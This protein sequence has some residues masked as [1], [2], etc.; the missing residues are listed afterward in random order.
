MAVFGEGW[1]TQHGFCVLEEG[2]AH[3]WDAHGSKT[4]MGTLQGKEVWNEARAE[5]VGEA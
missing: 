4:Q 2:S 5:V 1:G 3:R